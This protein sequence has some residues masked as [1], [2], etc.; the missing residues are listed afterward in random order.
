VF[1]PFT[2]LNL[3]YPRTAESSPYQGGS[4]PP[5]PNNGEYTVHVAAQGP[6]GTHVKPRVYATAK[7]KTG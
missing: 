7:F 6:N 1:L 5:L 3:G 2:L 4:L